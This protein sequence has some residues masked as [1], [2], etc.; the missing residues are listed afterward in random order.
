MKTIILNLGI[1]NIKSIKSASEKLCDTEVISDKSDFTEA[2]ILILPG[3]GSFQKGVEEIKK[4]GFEKI[5]KDFFL[6]KKKII[7]I[8]LGLQLMMNDSEESI[9]SNGLGL[10]NGS[11]SKIK[12]TSLKLPLLGWYDVEFKDNFFENR[13]YFFNN[14]YV[15]FPKNESTIIGKLKNLSAFVKQDNFYGFQFHPEK[16]GKHGIELLKKTIYS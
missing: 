8:C 6:K 7:A 5:I 13:S 4:R 15:V 14:N 1:N 10:I 12:D 2:D 11:V 3:N 9:N 16:S